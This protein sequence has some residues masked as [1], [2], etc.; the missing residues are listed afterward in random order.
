MRDVNNDMTRKENSKELAP[1]PTTPVFGGIDDDDDDDDDILLLL[2]LVMMMM[3]KLLSHLVRLWFVSAECI[4]RLG[5]S[6]FWQQEIY[7]L[8]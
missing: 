8:M 7:L 4:S 1:A 6:M 2:L 5:F 3:M